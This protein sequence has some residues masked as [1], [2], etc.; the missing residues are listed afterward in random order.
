MHGAHFL[1]IRAESLHSTPL[2]RSCFN[3]ET[4]THC[5]LNTLH[6]KAQYG[7]DSI[8]LKRVTS[9]ISDTVKM[10]LVER[11]VLLMWFNMVWEGYSGAS[12]WCDSQGPQMGKKRTKSK[13]KR[14]NGSIVGRMWHPRTHW[15]LA[16][17][18]SEEA[19]RT[20]ACKSQTRDSRP[21][22]KLS[23]RRTVPWDAWS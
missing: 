11:K 1:G 2:Q 17:R 14:D 18:M 7:T 3:S 15:L 9:P 12:S 23:L 22:P 10:F 21:S 19:T 20:A 6:N 5:L 8:N 4:P 13:R 16:L